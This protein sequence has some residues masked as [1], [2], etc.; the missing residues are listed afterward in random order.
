M[1]I[2]ELENTTW[3]GDGELWLDPLGND[4][5]RCACTMAITPDAIS[6]AWSYQGTPQTGRIVVRPDGADFSDTWHA[7]TGMVCK[8]T[9]PGWGLLDVFTTYGAGEGPDWGWGIT[10]ALRSES[11]E[12]VLQMTNVKPSGEHGRAVRIICRRD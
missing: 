2:S 1:T 3:T 9:A 12:L 7:P 8:A 6:Y 4:A 11:D 5:E 10:L